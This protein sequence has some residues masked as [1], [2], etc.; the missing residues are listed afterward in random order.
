MATQLSSNV[1]MGNPVS[2][3]ML[4]TGR[5]RDIPLDRSTKHKNS[6]SKTKYM[7]ASTASR[8]WQRYSSTLTE[9]ALDYARPFYDLI[10]AAKRKY[11]PNT[12]NYP[13]GFVV[14][15]THVGVKPSNQIDPDLAL[16][17]SKSPCSAAAV[18]TRNRFQAAPVQVSREVLEA[19][20]GDGIRSIIINSGC[21][22]AVTGKQGLED[23]RSMVRT[24]D[25]TVHNDS[26]TASD[27][28]PSTIVMSTGVIGQHLP[29][30]KITSAIPNAYKAL[31]S[32]HD[33]WLNTARAICT[34]DTFPKLLSRNFTLPSSRDRVY[35][36]AGMTKGAGMIH[37]NMATLLGIMC[38][39]VPISSSILPTLLKTAV[40]RSFNCISV[41]GDTSTNDTLAILANGAGGG[42]PIAS[43][44]DADG[45]ELQKI[46]LTFSQELSQLVVRDGEGATKFVRVQ[47]INSPTSSAA[48]KIAS[49]IAR[50]PLVK[51]AL[52]GRDAN[53]GR[54]LCAIGYTADLGDGVVIPERT[55]VS[56]I[57]AD[58]SKE[59]KLLVNGEPVDF[60]EARAS[61]ILEMEDLEIKVDLGTGQKTGNYW[62]CDFSHEVSLDS[63]CPLQ[64]LDLDYLVSESR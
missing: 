60:D 26:Y 53:W 49:T 42:S 61:Q 24:V 56:F 28:L 50:S 64:P 4:G 43:L 37:P 38:T 48:R 51:T 25:E 47:I 17:T 2:W 59:L 62:F 46:L 12:G 5:C 45:K 15:G 7:M 39:D 3:D 6:I 19:R 22:N 13:Q 44:H 11:V 57:P 63:N 41:D 40:N 34:T 16:I 30:Q 36:L 33:S 8:S 35:S 55:S 58:G 31:S 18:F 10:P 20:K 54:I 23:A 29:I 14:S 9:Q 52:Y 27:T 32:T 21:A 1:D